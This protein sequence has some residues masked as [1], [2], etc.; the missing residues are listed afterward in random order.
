MS[1]KGICIDVVEDFMKY[2]DKTPD[3]I[4]ILKKC[5]NTKKFKSVSN[6]NF[7]PC[8][9]TLFG[10]QHCYLCKFKISHQYIRIR[11]LPFSRHKCVYNKCNK[12]NCI[13]RHGIF[14]HITK[15][16]GGTKFEDSYKYSNHIMIIQLIIRFIRIHENK[17]SIRFILPM[18]NIFLRSKSNEIYSQLPL[19]WAIVKSIIDF[20]NITLYEYFSEYIYAD[21]VEKIKVKYNIDVIDTVSKYPKDSPKD[22]LLQETNNRNN[23]SRSRSNDKK[24]SSKRS[25]SRSN[26]KKRSSKRSRSRSCSNNKKRS[27]KRSRSRS[28]SPE[29]RYNDTPIQPDSKLEPMSMQ[30]DS[31]LVPMS[32]QTDSKSVPMSIQLDPPP[33]LMQLAP[34]PPLSIQGFVP[35]Q[36]VQ[37]T[38]GIT[39]IPFN[40][41]N[42]LDIVQNLILHNVDIDKLKQLSPEMIRLIKGTVQ[43]L[44]MSRNNYTAFLDFINMLNSL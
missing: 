41:N 15:D 36:L 19:D 24:R 4:D 20:N 21:I 34:P 14:N 8:C 38:N 40:G 1:A 43:F 27:N 26:D 13:N 37:S 10:T 32:I 29:N 5:Q 3:M 9:T 6:F 18:I 42:Y 17:D 23:R 12:I 16:S 30:T 31:K 39:I 28:V 7:I 25:R 11:D 22:Y 2:L 35:P 33:M 44:E